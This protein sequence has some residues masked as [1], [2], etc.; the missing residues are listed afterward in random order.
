[1]RRR[2]LTSEKELAAF[3][4]CSVGE[5]REVIVIALLLG[6]PYKISLGIN[7]VESTGYVYRKMEEG[8]EYDFE[9]EAKHN[10][11]KNE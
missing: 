5:L 6:I 1:M 10:E 8:G 4:G 7:I 9:F 11:E 2:E 3:V